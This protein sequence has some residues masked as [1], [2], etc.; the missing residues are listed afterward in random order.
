MLLVVGIIAAGVRR[1]IELS[2][3][4]VVPAILVLLVGPAAYGFTLEGASAAYA[5]YL[6]PDFGTIAANW[7]EIPPGRRSSPS[8]S[9]RARSSC[10]SPP[11]PPEF[12]AAAPSAPSCSVRSVWRRSHRLSASSKCSSRLIDE[13]GVARVPASAALG[14][15]VFLLGVPVTIDSPF[16]GLYDGSANGVLLVLGSL[17][18]ALF[19]GLV[20]PEAGREELREGVADAGSID[21]IWIWAVRIPIP[22]AVVAVLYL[23]V[24]DYAGFLTGDFA[25]W[26]AA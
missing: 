12:P 14:A 2:V 23:G 25:D 20:I 6:S 11:R 9:G 8:R 26:L 13:F 16:L 19:V 3:K 17:L 10:A 1:G 18:L 24:V 22:I 7:T 5:Y 15:A 4:V 21:S